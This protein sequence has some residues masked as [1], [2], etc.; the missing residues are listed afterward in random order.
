VDPVCKPQQVVLVVDD[1][2]AVLSLVVTILERAGFEVLSAG[3]PLQAL[4]LAAQRHG[5]IDLLVADVVMPG[6]SGPMLADSLA[7]RR[8][9]MRHLFMA[10]L[11]DSPEIRERILARGRPFLAKPFVPQTLLDKV[12]GVLGEESAPLAALT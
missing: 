12:R 11:P 1:E 4:Q 8:P 5:T 9:E 6:L 10:G 7:D 2:P 3:C